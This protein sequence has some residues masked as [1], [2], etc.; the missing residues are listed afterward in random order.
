MRRSGLFYIPSESPISFCLLAVFLSLGNTAVAE[1]VLNV[2][3]DGPLR[4]IA[5]ARDAIRRLPGDEAVRVVVA[6]GVYPITVPIVFTPED[7]GKAGAPV[8]YEAASG[9]QPVVSGGKAIDGFAAQP[10]GTWTASVDP[11]W[12]FEQL[13][14]NGR[15]AVRAREPDAFFYY[16]RKAKETMGETLGANPQPIARQTLYAD[17]RDL[18]TLRDLS[19]AENHQ[20][21]ILLFH[22]WDNTRKF[23]DGIDVDACKLLTSGKQMKSWNPLTRDTAY[24]LENYRA[25]MDEPG[26]WFL[27]DD[28]TLHYL[29]R[30]G[31]TPN[32]TIA[33]A[34]VADKLI[35]IVGDPAAGKFVEHLNFRGI[36]FQHTGWQTPPRGFEPTQA[37]ASIEAAVQIDGARSV[38]FHDCEI[39]RVATYGLWLRKGCRDSQVT[40]CDLHDLGAGGIRIGDMGISENKEER[41][42]NITIDNNFIRHG[43]RVF[44]CAVGVWIG[45]SGNNTVTHNEIADLYYTGISVGWRWGYS[46]SLAVNNRIEFNHIHHLGWGWLS[47]MGGVYTLGPSAGTSISNNVIHDILAWGYGGWGLYNDEGSTGILMENNLVYRTKSGGYHQHYG[48]DN[49]IRNNIFAYSREY[50]LKRSRVEDHLS[51]TLERNVIEWDSGRLFNGSWS[52]D[53]VKLD[54]NLYWRSDGKPIDFAGMT[55]AQWQASGKDTGSI[56]ADPL[57]ADTANDDFRLQDDAPASKIGF[58]PF[59]TSKAGV[60]GDSQW[61]AKSKNLTFPRMKQP[62]PTPVLAVREDFEAGELPVATSVSQDANRPGIEVVETEAAHSGRHALRM[63]DASDLSH[64][65]YP[66]FVVAPEHEEGVSRCDFAIKLGEGAVFQHEWRDRS[67]PYRIGPSLW[68]ENHQLR[69]GTGELLTLPESEWFKIQITAPLGEDAGTWDLVVTLPDGQTQRFE[70]LP[71][72]SQD[73]RTLQWLGFVSQADADSVVWID[74]LELSTNLPHPSP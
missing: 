74:D 5:E 66:M 38:T 1:R 19:A 62:P 61:V 73:W 11:K 24:V 64:R 46:D 55:F 71:N 63:T 18:A 3:P 59:D 2:S 28:G 13:W 31:E 25:A 65:Y 4:S 60:Y 23:L 15:R 43:G 9:A 21:Q 6:E 34:P 33:I 51:F 29:P 56:V 16:L 69:V 53:N 35:E 26:E 36:A 45:Q 22:K 12:R 54:H 57:F 30:P 58:I 32:S 17:P 7:S 10:D 27:D 48:R 41:T 20:A 49:L 68:I 67:Q 8:T 44:P 72:K 39:G 37:A 70:K 40:H 50:Q 47:D 52:D 14:V 42:S